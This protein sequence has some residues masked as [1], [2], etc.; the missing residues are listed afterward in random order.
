MQQETR[1]ELRILNPAQCDIE[2]IALLHMDHAGANS[3]RKITDKIFSRLE[4]L[5]TFPYIGFKLSD[6]QLAKE[7]YRGLLCDRRY[8]SIYRPTA[9]IVFVYHIVDTRTD[10]KGKLISMLS[11]ENLADHQ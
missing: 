5:S 8:L 10:Y 4:M 9:E 6:A 7:G 3:A 11:L 2:R 1:L